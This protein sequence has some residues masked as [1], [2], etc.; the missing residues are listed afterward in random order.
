M[1]TKRSTAEL[2]FKYEGDAVADGTMDMA[3]FGQALVG[4]SK[5]VHATINEI[6]PNAQI[7]DVRI[8]RTEKGSFKVVAQVTQDVT[9]VQRLQEIFANFSSD[10]LA[11]ISQVS[12]LN[13]VVVIGGAVAFGKWLKGRIIEKRKPTG[14]KGEEEITLSDGEVTIAPT[15]QINLTQKFTFNE[16]VRDVIEPTKRPG[17]DRVVL[18]GPDGAGVELDP[19]DAMSFKPKID[20]DSEYLVERSAL[21]E[22]ERVA[23]DDGTWRFAQLYDDDR[24]PKSFTAVVTDDEF[25]DKVCSSTQAFR[26]KDRIR[27]TLETTIT[28]PHGNRVVYRYEVSKVHE[29]IPYYPPETLPGL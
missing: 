29:I 4:Y 18:P 14:K 1:A 22:V 19:S 2:T 26:N 15:I 17:V 13:L 23:F 24:A 6:D 12:G 5:I 9:V 8:T 3:D 27:A 28:R 10:S 21:L 25:L 11:D 20:D 7:P 16:G